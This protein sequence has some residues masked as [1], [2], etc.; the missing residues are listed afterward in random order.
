MTCIYYSLTLK[1]QFIEMENGIFLGIG[2]NEGLRWRFMNSAKELIEQH[3]CKILE[4][5]SVYE[6]P[7]WGFESELPFLN[8]V[9]RIQTDLEPLE[10][11]GIL[12]QI[13]S[14]LGRVRSESQYSSRTIDID[15]LFYHQVIIDLPQIQVPHP[16]LQL[17]KFVL[18]PMCELAP[19]FMHPILCQTMLELNIRCEDASICRIVEEI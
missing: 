3:G 11:L 18:E 10:L 7:A 14:N 17:R 16:R 2:G 8:Q 6:S 5:S 9:I 4:A 19:D 13:E 12:H 1:Q 15:L